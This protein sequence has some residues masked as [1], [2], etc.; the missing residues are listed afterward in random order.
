MFPRN[1]PK[2]VLRMEYVV[3]DIYPLGFSRSHKE[4]CKGI[5]KIKCHEKKRGWEKKA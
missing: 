5:R 3:Y 1:S 2:A 4:T